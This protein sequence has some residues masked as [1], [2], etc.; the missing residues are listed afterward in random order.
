MR[1]DGWRHPRIPSRNR[2]LLYRHVRAFGSCTVPLVKRPRGEGCSYVQEREILV[3]PWYDYF[4]NH[5][6]AEE[7]IYIYKQ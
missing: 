6:G 2:A 7:F 5:Q 1:D 4:M 3:C